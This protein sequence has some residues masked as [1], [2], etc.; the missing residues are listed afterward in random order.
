MEENIIT[1]GAIFCHVKRM[2]PWNQLINSITCGNQKC[3]GDIP[4]L[5]A[6]AIEIN[7]LVDSKLLKDSI[8]KILREEKMIIS[9]ARA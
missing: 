5:I 4:N 6:R 8:F 7:L 3:V 1:I 2:D 9:E